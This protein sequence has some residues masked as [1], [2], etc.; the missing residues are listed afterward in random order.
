MWYGLWLALLAGVLITA[1]YHFEK[2]RRF[3]KIDQEL[4]QGLSNVTDA[5]RR[6]PERGPAV[7]GAIQSHVMPSSASLVVKADLDY[8]VIWMSTT[9]PVG[10]SAN[11]PSE[12]PKPEAGQLAVRIRG[13]RREA[14]ISAAPVDVLMVGRSVAAELADLSSLL[15]LLVTIGLALLGGGLFGG[16]WIVSRAIQPVDDIV[17]AALKIEAGDLRQRISEKDGCGEL[18][19][20]VS[21]LNRT[22]ERLA[23]VFEH[24]GRFIGDAAHELRT[25]VAIMLT[26]I[27]SALATPLSSEEYQETL[28]ACQRAAQRM[29]RLIEGLLKLARLGAGT[30]SLEFSAVDITEVVLEVLEQQRALAL[31]QKIEWKT[32]LEPALCRGEREFLL[33]VAGNLVNNAIHYNKPNGWIRVSTFTQDDRI[34]LKVSNAGPGIPADQQPLVFERFYRAEKSRANGGHHSGL[35][36]AIVEAIVKAHGGDVTLESELNV[37][38]TFTV[39]LP[40]W[41]TRPD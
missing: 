39:R 30:E 33:Q 9:E 18:V 41:G 32:E 1:T 5:L 31:E 23:T 27:Q 16:M 29:R 17:S 2:E 3:R 12:I 19:D 10:I 34:I 21:V 20:L 28:Q 36:L 38:T 37:Q 14:F 11:A 8:V 26:Q 22:F 35:G 4:Q 24:Q 7:A 6:M 25:P 15:M 40:A 13:D